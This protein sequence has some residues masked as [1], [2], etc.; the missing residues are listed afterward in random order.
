MSVFKS[1]LQLMM[2]EENALYASSALTTGAVTVPRYE[3]FRDLASTFPKKMKA[4]LDNGCGSGRQMEVIVKELDMLEKDGVYIAVDC[5]ED[6]IDFIR[7][8]RPHLVDD[9]RVHLIQDFAQNTGKQVHKILDGRKLDATI[10]SFPHSLISP[11]DATKIWRI[12][13]QHSADDA[14]GTVYNVCSTANMMKHHWNS[15]DTY[16]ERHAHPFWMP[17]WFEVNKG[18][19]PKRVT[20]KVKIFL[21]EIQTDLPSA[22]MAS[23]QAVAP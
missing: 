2:G 22:P 21:P 11:K 17:P 15:V 23:E 13:T 8:K 16:K 1:A 19:G 20:K 4:V 18:T 5:N 12:S 9:K 7:R 14:T 6:M 3:F 10:A